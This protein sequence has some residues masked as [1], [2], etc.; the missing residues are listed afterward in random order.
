MGAALSAAAERRRE[1]RLDAGSLPDGVR[2][3]IRPGHQVR[4]VNASPSGLLIEGASR[5]LP[6]RAVSV[7]VDWNDQQHLSQARVLRCEVSSLLPHA[8]VYRSALAME[9][10]VAW[11]EALAVASISTADVRG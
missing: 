7:H 3:R 10:T 6:G 1:C 8:V 11:F 4:V 9:H 5:L 2:A